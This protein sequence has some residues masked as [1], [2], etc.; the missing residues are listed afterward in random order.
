ML[1]TLTK[2][3]ENINIENQLH[4]TFIVDFSVI[5]PIVKKW[6]RNRDCD[7]IRVKEL[8]DFYLGG[9]Y[10]PKILHLA[11]LKDSKTL[12]CYD[13]NHRREMFD[14]LSIDQ[15]KFK[16]IID[17][18]FNATER[19][20][21]ESFDNINKSVQ[22]PTIYLGNE[23]CDVL[24]Q[25]KKL[26]RTY[27]KRYPSLMSSSARCIRPHFNRDFL[28]DN[29]HDLYKSLNENE[30]SKITIGKLGNILEQLNDKYSKGEM[31]KSHSCF[32]RT[33]VNKCQQSGLWLFIENRSVVIT[34]IEKL[35]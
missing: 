3:G 28:I 32:K 14:N 10:I 30:D 21:Y 22:L 17:V 12:V 25:I 7:P 5:S 31:C 4:K 13:G 18:I 33:V 19:D 9:G 27:E 23:V 1:E 2:L 8:Y 24:P 11:E 16:I 29:I 26:V 20:I 35:I 6:S 15:K 34:D